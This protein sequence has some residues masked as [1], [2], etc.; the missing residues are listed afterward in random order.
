MDYR[1]LNN[2]TIKNQYLLPLISKLLD[3]LGWAKRFSQLDLTNAYHRMRICEGDEWKIAFQT[4]YSY[5]KY[6]VMLFGLFNALATFQG[7]VNKILAEKLDIFVIVYLDNI[8]I[9]TKDLGQ[10]HIK[11]VYWFLDQFWKYSL[12]ANLKKCCFHQDEICFLGY[13]VSSKG[14]SIEVKRI[15]VIWEWPEPKSIQ[16]MQVFLDFA[17]FYQQFI[18][19]F[20]KIATPL[21][22]ML[23][24]TVSS[25]MLVANELFAADEVGGVEGSD[26]SIEKCGK[27]SK[28]GK[29]SKSENLKGKKSV[30]SKKSSKVGIHLILTLWKPA[31]TS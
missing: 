2:I 13:V 27:L 25:H 10:P 15:E 29:L 17:N 12:F 1:G 19:S 23:K 30:K 20:S 4:R 28:T 3:W 18:Q 9:Y 24:T 8:L 26:E 7:Y 14:I 22:S 11:T 31:W 5:F 16:D 6:Q 21:T